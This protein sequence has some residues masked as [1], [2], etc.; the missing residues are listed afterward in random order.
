MRRRTATNRTAANSTAAKTMPP[1]APDE[2]PV[3]SG[4][5]AGGC[6]VV[7]GTTRATLSAVN[8]F[9]LYSSSDA[10]V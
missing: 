3:D 6:V 7:G 1:M 10:C 9:C 4:L 2:R 8:P 5:L